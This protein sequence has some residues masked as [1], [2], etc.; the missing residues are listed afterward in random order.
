MGEKLSP[1]QLEALPLRE[2][3]ESLVRHYHHLQNEHKRAPLESAPRR[4]IEERLLDVRARFDRL[5]EEWVQDEDLRQAWVEHLHNRAAAPSEPAA[6]HPLVFRGVSEVSGSAVEIRGRQ[7]EELEVRVDGALV[8]RRAGEKRL[9]SPTPPLRFELEGVGEFVETFDASPESLS[10][11]ADFLDDTA[12][13]PPWD[14]AAEL[15]ADGEIET[16]F[17]LTPRGRRALA[18]R[19]A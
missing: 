10:A 7:G 1:G 11:L 12:Q 5:L 13:P 17:A 6:I 19:A 18:S 15:L 4:R 16:H 9:A 3:L 8:E 14:Y 2:S